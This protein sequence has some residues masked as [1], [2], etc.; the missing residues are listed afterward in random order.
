MAEGEKHTA[1]RLELKARIID[2][3]SRLFEKNGIKGVTMDHIAAS[4]GISK[5]TLYE[6]FS[7]KETL[8]VECVR[9]GQREADAYMRKVREN[10]GNVLEVLLKGYQ[11]S[12]EKFHATNKKFY[13]EIKRY[14]RAYSLIKY[15]DNRNAE[16][17]V[18]F[19]REGVEQGFFRNDVNFAIVGLLVREQLDILMGT[20]LCAQYPFLE[21]YESIMFISLRGISTEKGAIAL[22]NFIREYRKK[23]QAPRESSE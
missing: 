10:S 16:D 9:R 3:A 2:T 23:Q 20:D 8:L 14:P 18:S 17:I 19:F 5:R 11:Q 22:D 13:E 12:I 6:V 4:F 15:G 7:D 21:V 1:S